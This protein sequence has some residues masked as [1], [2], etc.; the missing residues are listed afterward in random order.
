MDLSLAQLL[1][2]IDAVRIGPL[3]S[4]AR[5]YAVRRPTEEVEHLRKGA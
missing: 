5:V 4:A 3:A 2:Q 1:N